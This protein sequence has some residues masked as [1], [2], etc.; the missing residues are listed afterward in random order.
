LGILGGFLGCQICFDSIDVVHDKCQEPV[1]RQYS[2]A[3]VRDSK[4]LKVQSAIVDST[5]FGGRKGQPSDHGVHYV[6]FMLTLEGLN[7][8]V[9]YSQGSVDALEEFSDLWDLESFEMGG[10]NVRFFQ[11]RSTKARVVLEPV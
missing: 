4:H 10:P 1:N 11:Y 9:R 5:D 3:H 6:I 8:N 2:V 7:G